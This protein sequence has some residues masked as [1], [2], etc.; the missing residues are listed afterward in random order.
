QDGT[1]KP[2]WVILNADEN[3]GAI[4]VGEKRDISIS[5]APNSAAKTNAPAVSEGMY[6]F[7]L[8]VSSSNYAVTDILLVVA[9]T[10]SGIG[11]VKFKVEDIYTGTTDPKTSQL[12]E[13]IRVEDHG[14]IKLQ[15]IAA[16]GTVL[17]EYE[18]ALDIKG[19][20]KFE[21]L[22]TGRYKYRATA[23]NHQEMIGTVWI[24]PGATIEE[25][26]FLAY[27]LVTVE[28]EVTETT[29]QDKYDIVL[30]ARYETNVPAPVIVAD[31]ASINIPD[32]MKPGDVLT[33][34][35]KYTNYGLI[36]ADDL[37][38]TFP[39]SDEYFKYEILVKSLPTSLG[40]KE[41]FTVPYRITCLKS[42]TGGTTKR[43][44][45]CSCYIKPWK[46]VYVWICANGKWF[47][48]GISVPIIECSGQC[49]AF[50]GFGCDNCGGGIGGGAIFIPSLIS[51]SVLCPPEDPCPKD[52]QCCLK[53]MSD[54]GGSEINL[55]RGEYRDDAVDLSVKV[56]GHLLEV[57]RYYYDN[58]WHFAD[59]KEHLEIFYESDGKTPKYIKKHG[60]SYKK[61]DEQ[62]TVYSFDETLRILRQEGGYRWEDGSGNWKLYDLKGKIISFGNRNNQKV[63]FV[64]DAGG[65]ITGL[66][67]NSDTQVL[68]YEYIGNE[69][70]AVHDAK[71][72]EVSYTYESGRLSKVTDVLGNTW[73]YD[74]DNQGRLESKQDPE[75]H[76]TKITYNDFGYV[77]S[78]IFDDGTSKIFDYSYDAGKKEYYASVTYKNSVPPDRIREVWYNDKGKKLR[79]KKN[80]SLVEEIIYEGRNERIIDA[81][82][83][84]TYR[85]Y[86][87]WHNLKRETYPDGSSVSYQYESKFNNRLRITDERGVVTKYEYDA[88]GNRTKKIEAY[89]TSD[90]RITEYT[91][92]NGNLKTEKIVGDANTLESVSVMAYDDNGNLESVTDAEGNTTSYTYNEMGQVETRTDPNGNIWTYQYDDMGNLEYQRDPMGN[93]T[94]YAYD[95]VG[96]K[97]KDIDPA[98][99][100]TQYEYDYDR[101]L[102]KITDAYG[103]ITQFVYT[104]GKLTKRIDPEGKAVKQEYDA[105]GRL[106]KTVDGNGNVIEYKYENTGGT[107]CQTCSGGAGSDTPTQVIYPTNF[108]KEF[109]YDKRGRKEIEKDIVGTEQSLTK[110]KYDFSG[111]MTSQTD[112]E[113]HTTIYDYDKLGRKVKVTD[114]ISGVTEYTYDDRNN[115]IALKDANGNITKFEYDKNNRL[116]KEIRPMG[117]TTVYDYDSAGS[118]IR[119][120]DAKAQKTE[121]DYDDTGRMKIIR[122]YGAS[123]TAPQKAVNFEYY[124]NGT[125]KSYTDGATSA[126]Y[127]YDSL[128]RKISETVNYG[129]FQLVYGYAYY[130]NGLKKSFIMPDGTV[131]GYTYDNNNQLTG[132]SVPGKGT[133]AYSAYKWNRPESVTLPGGV[134]KAYS[135]DP[136]MRLQTIAVKDSA[137]KMLMQYGYT[138]DKMNNIQAKQ[139]EHG[140]YG[141]GYDPIYR[142]KTAD[143]A[144]LTDEAYTYD[145]VGNR[146]TSADVSGSW[147]YNANNELRAYSG[148][149]FEY[150]NNGNMTKQSVNG[151]TV[152]YVYDV[153]N[154]L[155][156]V[157]KADGTVIAKYY[158]DPFGRRLSKEVNGVKTFFLYADEG[159]VGEYDATGKETKAYGYKPNSI[160]TTDP[161]FMKQGSEYYFYHNDHLG[162]PVQ[163]TDASGN[164]KWSAKYDSFGKVQIGVEMVVNNLRFPGQYFDL[165]TGLDYNYDRLYDPKIGRYLRI[166]SIGIN[167]GINLYVFV[168]NNPVKAIDP[169]GRSTLDELIRAMIESGCSV[170]DCVSKMVESNRKAREWFDSVNGIYIC[171]IDGKKKEIP[172]HELYGG[173]AGYPDVSYGVLH[174]ALGVEARRQGVSPRCL[175]VFNYLWEYAEAIPVMGTLLTGKLLPEWLE[176]YPYWGVD[177]MH[178]MYSV[179]MGYHSK[180]NKQNCIPSKCKKK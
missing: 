64:Y 159:L 124:Q 150:D 30:K 157:N 107:S 106:W 129:N 130:K 45:S 55:L 94:R 31:P 29:I 66:K 32:D 21:N 62:G 138:Y 60:V 114:A 83:Y 175:D 47:E 173:L 46:T 89:Q 174:C 9:V 179:L 7:Y 40:A 119:K 180:N 141:F 162:T 110:F 13:G 96:N 68:W 153:E 133:V 25:K 15:L 48:A 67:D 122:Y 145:A 84:E 5:F 85:E 92:E 18:Q 151:Q 74:Y 86:D 100:I 37:Q 131:Y 120:S 75:G 73:I 128:N 111:N 152:M 93:L 69:I 101:H 127:S 121:Y 17:K 126:T 109:Q 171:C 22:S 104:D 33:G 169:L 154:R 144:V 19:E 113:S 170:F 3:Q 112:K 81:N 149:S 10:K 88:A 91:Y 156:Q 165:E 176:K 50:G 115:L 27:N 57:K 167:G 147:T 160:W 178:D 142:L 43:S 140:N 44:G 72:R 23:D 70:S 38:F 102:R 95:K 41:F 16:D 14:K 56:P 117:E 77:Q 6:Q 20:T 97:I 49:H 42:L 79:E 116:K 166:D 155:I 118:L 2:H 99:N 172:L 90:E 146:L 134:S 51:L 52:D 137:Q 87:E 78:V 24:K 26:I 28:W 135:Y 65:K 59:L 8:R 161:V 12:I 53:G 139:T 143:N 54:P 58:A 39:E 164:T 132:I 136:M 71:N 76:L 34:E 108:V 158:Y 1:P 4:A 123:E 103:N 163:M 148:N 168:L 177:V 61:A 36:R 98:G 80:G 11:N 82:G 125:L 63:S 105:E 35:I